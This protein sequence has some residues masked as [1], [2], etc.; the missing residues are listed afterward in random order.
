MKFKRQF[1]GKM[2]AL[3]AGIAWVCVGRIAAVTAPVLAS[4]YSV[5]VA[6]ER[7]E[8]GAQAAFQALQAEDPNQLSGHQPIIRR[9]D[10]GDAGSYYRALI[11]PFASAEKAAKVSSGLKTGGGDCI[12]AKNWIRGLHTAGREYGRLKTRAYAL[13]A[14]AFTDANGIIR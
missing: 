7:S 8:G 6:S 4:G 13:T 12:V 11:G 9:A 3:G 2:K 14:A 10:L 5:Q 1:E